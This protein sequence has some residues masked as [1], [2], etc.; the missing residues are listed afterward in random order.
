MIGTFCYFIYFILQGHPYHGTECI[1]VVNHN[2]LPLPLGLN[3]WHGANLW[4]ESDLQISP[5]YWI[6][7]MSWSGWSKRCVQCSPTPS[8]PRL[9]HKQQPLPAYSTHSGHCC[10]GVMLH[11]TVTLPLWSGFSWVMLYTVATQGHATG[12]GIEP[13]RTGADA[14]CLKVVR[15]EAG[16]GVESQLVHSTCCQWVTSE[17]HRKH[18]NSNKR[19]LQGEPSPWA[20][21]LTPSFYS[22]GS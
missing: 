17:T 15:V 4:A 2:I 7:H 9:H 14:M 19:V 1:T 10:F 22:N 3:E 6:Q 5:T 12:S 13:A 16:C 21:S 11:V 18:W 20:I 8:A